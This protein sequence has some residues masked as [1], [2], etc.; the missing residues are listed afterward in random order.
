MR[1][2]NKPPQRGKFP[3]RTTLRMWIRQRTNPQI[4]ALRK[5]VKKLAKEIADLKKAFKARK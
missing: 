2:L 3:S 1:K 5:D 4:R